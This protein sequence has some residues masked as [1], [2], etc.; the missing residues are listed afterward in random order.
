MPEVGPGQGAGNLGGVCLWWGRCAGRHET[1][2]LHV[3]AALAGRGCLVVPDVEHCTFLLY[4]QEAASSSA[5]KHKHQTSGGGRRMAQMMLPP[6]PPSRMDIDAAYV[7]HGHNISVNTA[8]GCAR[9]RREVRYCFDC[10]AWMAQQR[11]QKHMESGAHKAALARLAYHAE[12]ANQQARRSQASYDKRRRRQESKPPPP[13]M[14]R[15]SVK[16]MAH[17]LGRHAASTTASSDYEPLPSAE[18][19]VGRDSSARTAPRRTTAM[20]MDLTP[21][22]IAPPSSRRPCSAKQRR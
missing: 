7:G 4:A 21:G 16:T 2:V 6:P 18:R 11:V 20:P 9:A 22:R 8:K 5:Q 19:G 1:H 14:Q 17:V 10:G 13:G 3:L 12:G 15:K